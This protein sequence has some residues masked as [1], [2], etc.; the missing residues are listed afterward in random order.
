MT[1]FTKIVAPFAFALTASAASAATVTD[2]IDLRGQGGRDTSHEFTATSGDLHVEATGHY[3]NSDGSI[4]AAAQIGQYSQGLGVTTDTCFFCLGDSHMVD[5]TG[6]D[7]VVKFAF[8]SA[9]SIS[10]VYFSHTSSWDDFSF[11]VIGTGGSVMSFSGDLNILGIGYGYYDFAGPLAI[12]NIFG[13]GA[14]GTGDS[15]KIAALD[16]V[17]EEAAP[18][19][20]LPASALLMLGAFGGLGALR[21]RKAA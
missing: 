17:W 14:S 9:V 8:D 21:R 11:S 10:R 7:E 12:S 6:R 5:S 13:I 20:P 16:V 3:L 15:F 2:F 1:L 18:A 4:G 19:V